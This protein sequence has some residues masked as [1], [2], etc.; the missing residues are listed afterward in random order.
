MNLNSFLAIFSA[1]SV[2]CVVVA[3]AVA[4]VITGCGMGTTQPLQRHG[5]CA[6]AARL[7]DHCTAAPTR[8]QNAS[9]KLYATTSSGYGATGTL[10]ASTTSNSLGAYT[11]SGAAT[12]PSGQFA[13]VI[14]QGG[15]TGAQAANPNSLL[16][17]AVGPCA[18][19]TTSTFIWVDELTTVA[20]A[21]ALNNFI[22][23][24]GNSSS[25]YTVGVSSS[26]TNNSSTGSG[27]VHNAYYP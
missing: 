17:A 15:N 16:M 8:I 1:R 6:C 19:L 3:S 23:I 14:A 21:Y 13:Y 11:F 5:Y 2:R 26:A 18:S 24:T 25:G 20:A 27:C 10:L 7:R 22:T 12:C 9:V 4:V